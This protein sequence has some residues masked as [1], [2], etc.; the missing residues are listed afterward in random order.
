VPS[1]NLSKSPAP[2][3]VIIPAGSLLSAS[4]CN[5]STSLRVVFKVVKSPFAVKFPP[6]TKL[7]LI[8]PFPFKSNSVAVM[9]PAVI[10]L[11][12][13]PVK[14][15]SNPVAVTIPATS[16]WFLIQLYFHP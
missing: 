1:Y 3:C 5:I 16:P 15:P 8:S 7:P 4:T 6:T 12:E 2:V 10:F 13:P 11:L 9:I 14:G